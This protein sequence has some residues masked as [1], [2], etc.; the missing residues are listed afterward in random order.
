MW[1]KPSQEIVVG[2][3]IELVHGLPAV[4]TPRKAA[5]LALPQHVQQ[6][7]FRAA[8]LAL[9]G[10]PV[11][12]LV[13]LLRSDPGDGKKI[14]RNPQGMKGIPEKVLKLRPSPNL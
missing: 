8:G 6:L 1:K 10:K 4:V 13:H 3:N 2:S 9:R 12:L 5:G 7:L 14:A 11:E